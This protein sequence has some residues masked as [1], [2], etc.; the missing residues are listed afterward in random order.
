MSISRNRG[1]GK[2][3]TG[4]FIFSYLFFWHS[5]FPTDHS[6][7]TTLL[8]QFFFVCAS[9]ISYMTSVLS[10]F[11]PN[12]SFVLRFRKIVLRNCGLIVYLLIFWQ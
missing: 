4:M 10:V 5:S 11:V 1:V 2:Y 3:E 9:V 7:V 8:L 12:L 6:N